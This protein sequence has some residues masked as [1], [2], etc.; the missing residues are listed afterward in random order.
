MQHH[1]D[2]QLDR[3]LVPV[4]FILADAKRITLDYCLGNRQRIT[5]VVW[6]GSDIQ[7]RIVVCGG[8]VV[9]CRIKA[10]APLSQDTT[11][12]PAGEPPILA[13][14]WVMNE[15]A[16]WPGEQRR[17]N[18]INAFATARWRNDQDVFWSAML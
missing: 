16:R 6:R 9:A 4:L 10:H 17:D 11:A 8:A 18:R 1:G 2:Q 15:H 5:E 7:E 3:R 14:F 12:I 13:I